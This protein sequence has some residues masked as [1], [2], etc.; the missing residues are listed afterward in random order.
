MRE[1]ARDGCNPHIVRAQTRM[2]GHLQIFLAAS[3]T[4]STTFS[5][6]DFLDDAEDW[7]L[8]DWRASVIDKSSGHIITKPPKQ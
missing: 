2:K 5:V 7:E 6:R 3:L 1:H 8:F 4:A